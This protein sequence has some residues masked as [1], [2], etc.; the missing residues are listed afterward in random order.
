MAW[1]PV[2]QAAVRS[3]LRAK[4]HIQEELEQLLV[5]IFRPAR[6]PHIVKHRS[7]DGL[8]LAHHLRTG[9]SFERSD[10]G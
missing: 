7:E 5:R 1:P 10:A 3:A 8:D 6:R 4:E 9:R 2:T